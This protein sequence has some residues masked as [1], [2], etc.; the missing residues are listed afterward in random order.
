MILWH[1]LSPPKIAAL[2]L[3]GVVPCLLVRLMPTVLANHTILVEWELL[4]IETTRLYV[5]I[6]ID[7]FRITF[8]ITVTMISLSVIIFRITYISGDP[9]LEYFIYIVI[10]FVLSITILIFIPNLIILLLGWDG[11]GLTSYLLVIYYQSDSSL[12]AGIVTALTNRIG[13]ALLILAGAWIL[14]AGNWNL[15]V[16]RNGVLWFTAM[17]IMVAAITKRAQMPFSAWLPA[18]MAAPTPVSSLVHS[19]TLVTAGVYLIFRFYETLTNFWY[20]NSFI[21]YTGTVTCLIASL[22]ATFEWDFKKVIALSTLS[23]LGVIIIA[24]GLSQPLLAFFHLVTHALFK[25][26]LF[27]CAGNIIHCKQNNQDLRL[28]GNIWSSIPVTCTSLNVANIALCGLPFIAGFY[29]KDLI[30]ER[31]FYNNHPISTRLAILAGACLTSLYSIRLS[32]YTLWS[33]VKSTTARTANDERIFIYTPCLILLTGAISGGATISWLLLP[34]SNLFTL[35]F[36]LKIITLTLILSIA[37]LGYF[38]VTNF[39]Q[40]PGLHFFTTIWFL[41]HITSPP[42]VTK[43]IKFSQTFV[44]NELTWIELLSGKGMFHRVKNITL[45]LQKS[46]GLSFSQLYSLTSCLLIIWLLIT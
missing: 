19:S 41:T 15:H 22:A 23:Q 44:N 30:I 17:A 11:L 5:P 24:L 33:P 6:L 28:M 4:R 40:I 27:I 45:T 3:L 25:A 26:L 2:F 35:P 20:F 46:Q 39:T 16:T 21:F 31:I 8:G 42:L 13:D 34:S 12:G 29:S 36:A 38:L 1:F 37:L 18:A 9:N 7:K 10:L 14:S 43:A 32:I